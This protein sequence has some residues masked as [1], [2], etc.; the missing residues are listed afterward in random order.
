MK[1]IIIAIVC[2]LALAM[3]AAALAE[4]MQSINWT[5]PE[6]VTT[7]KPTRKPTPTPKPTRKPTP[8]PKPT[9][10]PTPKPTPTP[11]PKPTATP[12]NN[13]IGGYRGAFLVKTKSHRINQ[14]R[15]II[16]D[17]DCAVDGDLNTAWNSNK[18][19]NGQ[20]IELSVA[21]GR[22]YEVA[23]FR[24]AN[25]YWKNDEVYT[26]NFRLRNVEAYCDNKLVAKYELEDIVS[27]Q[28]FWFPSPVQCSTF[29][30][31]VDRKSVV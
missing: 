17:G 25:G 12:R 23:G 9:P 7:P 20:W 5:T 31:V 18:K 22:S 16:V 21:D 28:T 30:L 19:T 10:P 24:I 3:P 1:R 8:T 11:R 6:P 29:K 4:D 26:N 14:D 15:S 27:Y 2:L 13:S